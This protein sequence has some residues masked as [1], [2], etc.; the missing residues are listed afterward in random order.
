[1][2][3]K[4]EQ[5]H[6]SRSE[7]LDE[8]W[9]ISSLV[10]TTKK[11]ANTSRKPSFDVS[12]TELSFTPAAKQD[13]SH[14]CVSRES[15]GV[16]ADEVFP[17]S[18]GA[19]SLNLP[20]AEVIT[21]QPQLTQPESVTY[22]PDHPLLEQ[23]TLHPWRNHFPY[24]ERFCQTA[25]ELFA[26]KG[27]PCSAVPFFSYMPQYDQMNRAQMSWYLY[28][29]DLVRKGEY[30]KTDHSYIFLLIFEI[31]NLPDKIPHERAL[32]LLCNIWLAYREGS[33]ANAW[34][35]LSAARIFRS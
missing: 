9:D 32:T 16:L 12:T 21:S 25:G 13:S 31:I 29:R 18:K 15:Q 11:T 28:W 33:C 4:K 26:A 17:I 3:E 10:V 34:R 35:A 20:T 5:K 7:E 22:K 24:Y 6:N 27:Q 1:M 2:S 23:V 8:F 30:P 14:P 19:S